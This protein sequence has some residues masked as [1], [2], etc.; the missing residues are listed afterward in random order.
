[1]VRRRARLRAAQAEAEAV[2]IVELNRYDRLRIG[3]AGI[4]RWLAATNAGLTFEPGRR[5]DKATTILHSVYAEAAV[6]IVLGVPWWPTVGTTDDRYTGDVAGLQ[7]RSTP[8]PAGCLI[9]REIDSPDFRYVLALTHEL[10]H[11]VTVVG[12]LDGAAAKVPEFHEPVNM[13]RGIHRACFM[14]P[15]NRLGPIT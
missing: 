3:Y 1:M 10:P 15:Q 12:G 11:R 6:A 4:D 13:A 7:V 2:V 8:R 5:D 9:V 14:V